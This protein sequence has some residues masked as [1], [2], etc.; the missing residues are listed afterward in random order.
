MTAKSEK[1][2]VEP[3]VNTGQACEALGV[4]R[5]YMAKVKRELGISGERR[6]FLSDVERHLRS[7]LRRRLDHPVV[8]AD[9]NGERSSKRGPKI[10]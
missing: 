5:T 3:M 2:K 7:R 9:M 8:T 10:S 6:F 4:G 1:G